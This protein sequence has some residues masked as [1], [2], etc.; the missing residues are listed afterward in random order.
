MRAEAYA[1]GVTVPRVARVDSEQ[2]WD[3]RARENALFY[4]D[5][6][7]GYDDPDTDAFWRRGEEVV[8]LMLGFVDLEIRP[9]EKVLDIGCGVGR[10]TRALAGRARHVYGLDV[11]REMLGLAEQHNAHLT[12]VE[13]VHGD[14]TS[15][16][17]VGDSVV[18]GC[19]SHVVFQHIP[20]SEIT[21]GYVRE[22]GRVLKPGGWA[23][24]QVSTDPSVHRPPRLRWRGRLKRLL[25]GKGKQDRA[26]WGSHVDIPKLRAAADE[27]GM[28]V[29]QVLDE[30]SQY[31]T[32]FAR[33]R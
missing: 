19:F 8:D 14:G 4:V 20:D 12:N 2:Y 3:E 15:L 31:T 16:R 27:A 21:L 18:D 23:L 9:D 22:M 6:E 10:L 28:D 26:W 32:V 13:W 29:E 24:F 30:G 17:G 33:R 25:T 5:N 1:R 11:S 7:I